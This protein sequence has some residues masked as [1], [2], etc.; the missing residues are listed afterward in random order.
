MNQDKKVTYKLGLAVLDIQTNKMESL[1]LYDDEVARVFG[2]LPLP[3]LENLQ[4][5]KWLS[6]K[7]EE[8][9]VGLYCSA[10]VSKADK[11]N[12]RKAKK[13]QFLYTDQ[14]AIVD[15]IKATTDDIT[16]DASVL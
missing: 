5:D 6:K 7:I 9:L 10:L 16:F 4:Q 11:K 2:C 8:L 14:L 15:L 1:A 3:Y 12:V 13:V